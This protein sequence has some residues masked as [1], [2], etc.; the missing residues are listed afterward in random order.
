LSRRQHQKRKEGM[1]VQRI[2]I[3]KALDELISNEQGMKFQGLAVI[4][5]K[6]KWPEFIACERK[7]DLGLD[8]YAKASVSPDGRGKG[9]ACSLTA[10]IDKINDDLSKVKKHFDDVEV[11]VFAT[12]QKVTNHTAKKWADQIYAAFGYELIVIPRE[13]II[14]SLMLPSNAAICRSQLGISVVIEAPV[15]ETIERARLAVSEVRDNWAQ[16]LRL[17]GQPYINLRAARLDD[18][19]TKTEELLYLDN[20]RT[21][22]QGGSRIVLEAPAGRG[23]TTTLIHLA[24]PVGGVAGLS[25][26]IDLPAWVKTRLSILDFVAQLPPFRA[27]SF[28]AENLS[29]RNHPTVEGHG[30]CPSC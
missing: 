10:T 25:I 27:R 21:L 16:S 3:E 2:D 8:A 29:A 28:S 11:L 26:L 12:P 14:A 15:E 20:I 18:R 17:K 5:A 19:G 7:W 4:L 23:K 13:E 1:T 30:R 6:Q 9:L 22:L 24:G